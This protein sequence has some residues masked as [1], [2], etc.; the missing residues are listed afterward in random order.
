M[1]VG[2]LRSWKVRAIVIGRICL[3]TTLL[4]RTSDW[5][6]HVTFLSK[7]AILL[8]LV[9]G[10]AIAVGSRMRYAA[11]LAFLGPLAA[12]M[13]APY[14]HLVFRPANPAATAAV[15]ITSGILVCFGQNT[16]KAGLTFSKTIHHQANPCAHSLTRPG[17]MIS[18]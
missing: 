4:L 8:E 9:L 11:A 6:S 13:L 2:T 7:L 17:R 10:A 16:E 3:A 14:L 12:A 5:A 15:L 1:V 18:K